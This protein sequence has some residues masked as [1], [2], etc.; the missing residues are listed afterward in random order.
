MRRDRHSPWRPH[1]SR[2]RRARIRTA[3]SFGPPCGRDLADGGDDVG[4][5]AAAAEVAAHELA[6]LRVGTRTPL[7]EERERGHDLAGGAVAALEPVVADERRLHRMQLSIG[8]QPLDRGDRP[9]VALRGESQAGEDP[10]AVKVNSA[11]ATRALVAALL[12]ADEAEVLAKRAEQRG[13]AVQSHPGRG[14]VY[15]EL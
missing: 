14:L 1:P 12:G 7:F 13:T 4:I 6:D 11:G 9:A 3:P 2:P 10:L 5:G 15:S 8:G